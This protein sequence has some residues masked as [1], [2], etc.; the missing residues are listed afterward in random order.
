MSYPLGVIKTISLHV[1]TNE[2]REYN[3]PLTSSGNYKIAARKLAEGLRI[4]YRSYTPQESVNTYFTVS[5]P[6]PIN[7]P[8]FKSAEIIETHS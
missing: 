4:V 7:L 2:G 5:G 8:G 1:V 3:V 6:G